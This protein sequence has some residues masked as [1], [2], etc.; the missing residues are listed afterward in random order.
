MVRTRPPELP[1]SLRQPC[2]DLEP[3]ADGRRATVLGWAI[4]A[5]EAYAVCQNRHRRAVEAAAGAGPTPP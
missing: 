4:E 1:A 3:L 2:P 5:K